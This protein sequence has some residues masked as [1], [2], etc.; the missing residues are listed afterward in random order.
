M[1]RDRVIVVN[2]QLVASARH[3]EYQLY[4]FCSLLLIGCSVSLVP[5]FVFYTLLV[6]V[7]LL[8]IALSLS[9]VIIIVIL[10]H[11]ICLVFVALLLS[12]ECINV[13][14]DGGVLLSIVITKLFV[15]VMHSIVITKPLISIDVLEVFISVEII[16]ERV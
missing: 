16:G 9:I 15:N 3:S 5:L 2:V 13:G 10:F 12:V 4:C 14:G 8:S 7:L 6:V 11:S 1:F